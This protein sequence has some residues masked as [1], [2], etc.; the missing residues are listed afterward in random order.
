MTLPE[1]ILELRTAKGLSQG[2]LAEQ[3]E[4]SRQSVSK[5]ETGQ[6]VPDLDKIIKLAGLFGVTVDE[7]V[8]R[9]AKPEPSHVTLELPHSTSTPQVVCV[10]K[11]PG[12]TPTKITGICLMV[13]GGITAL[14]TFAVTA[15][16]LLPGL[17][18]VVLGLP[19][20]LA[21]KHPWL[22]CGWILTGLGYAIFNPFATAT[23]LN[24]SIAFS[25]LLA[26]LS[27][28]DLLGFSQFLGIGIALFRGALTLTLLVLSLR[29][30]LRR[31]K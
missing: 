4:V 8:R 30:W 18:L 11:H 21:K 25:L 2:E 1:T 16:L 6:S 5:W 10:E 20:V 23:P 13:L 12:L 3:L 19:L 9:E 17:A 26:G 14:L 7:L 27:H 15:V 31:K 28:P 29:L 22:I 24:F